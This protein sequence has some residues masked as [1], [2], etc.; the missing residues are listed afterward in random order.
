[1]IGCLGF[2]IGSPVHP[3]TW[4]EVMIDRSEMPIKL[5]VEFINNTKRPCMEVLETPFSSNKQNVKAK[6]LQNII[7]PIKKIVKA[8]AVEDFSKKV[9]YNEIEPEK[10]TKKYSEYTNSSLKCDLCNISFKK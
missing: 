1:M 9:K 3:N 8:K 4:Y 10:P 7:N 6:L 5:Q 2:I